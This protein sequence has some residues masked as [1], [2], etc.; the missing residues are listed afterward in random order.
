MRYHSRVAI[1]IPEYRVV[2]RNTSVS[3]ENKIHDDAVAR[4]YGFRGGLV[5]GTTVYAYL[6]RAIV[7]AFGQEWLTRGRASLRL[8]KPVYDAEEIAVRAGFA[9][10]AT[11]EVTAVNAR[12][13]ACAVVRAAV[14][15]APPSPVDAS[16]YPRA[17]LPVER[18]PAE[19][20]VLERLS[21]LGSPSVLYDETTAAEY[22]DQVGE[23]G[24]MYREAAAC[25]HP[26]F[27]LQQANRALSQNVRLGPWIHV[28][29]EVQHH[30][31]G[32][33][34]DRIG[35]RG[36]VGRLF[37]KKDH[38]FVE[39]DVL[40]VADD[41]RPIARVLHTAIYRVAGGPPR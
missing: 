29:S 26:G 23:P 28:G 39:L 33:I 31:V 24:P 13:E 25:A 11:L 38:E 4:R 22:L 7:A 14:P 1:T 6:T 10:G 17:D 41:E 30:G 16:A 8:L 9:D 2:A 34:G 35:A 32:R 15:T 3:S 27:C 37:E 40:I 12:D 19:R 20:A 21:V 5:P 18:P 36:R